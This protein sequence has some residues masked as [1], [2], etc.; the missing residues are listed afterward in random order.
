MPFSLFGGPEVD[1]G[2][3]VVK[4]PVV[5]ATA[6]ALRLVIW[7]LADATEVVCATPMVVDEPSVDA[8]AVV[9]APV[10]LVA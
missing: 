1:G 7:R 5:V 2:G 10:V 8:A 4:V 3:A 6:V 9:D